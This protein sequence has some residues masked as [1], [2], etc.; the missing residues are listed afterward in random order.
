MD[1]NKEYL[2][3]Y[4]NK[5]SLK[6]YGRSIS[7]P[8]FEISNDLNNSMQDKNLY[9]KYSSNGNDNYCDNRYT[10]N[11]INIKKNSNN[12]LYDNDIRMNMSTFESNNYNLNMD[13]RE[14]YTNKKNNDI[15]TSEKMYITK[16]NLNSY[17]KINKNN[18]SSTSFNDDLIENNRKRKYTYNYNNYNNI[19]INNNN[20]NNNNNIPKSSMSY[21]NISSTSSSE[22]LLNNQFMNENYLKYKKS[23]PKCQFSTLSINTTLNDTI[24]KIE[25]KKSKSSYFP[26]TPTRT[27]NT[28]R[29]SLLKLPCPINKVEKYDNYPFYYTTLNNEMKSSYSYDKPNNI[30]I[31]KNVH[32][33]DFLNNTNIKRTISEKIDQIDKICSDFGNERDKQ[34]SYYSSYQT[35][36]NTFPKNI[37]N[38]QLINEI[39]NKK[40]SH[41]QLYD[42]GYN[43]LKS[44]NKGKNCN[45]EEKR[46]NNK[47][48]YPQSSQ[49]SFNEYS[50][51]NDYEN[52]FSSIKKIRINNNDNI[53]NMKISNS[54]FSPSY[55]SNNNN[56][57]YNRIESIN[58]NNKINIQ[59]LVCNN[60]DVEKG[61]N[62]Y[63]DYKSSSND[64]KN[65]LSY[66]TNLFKINNNNEIKSI[67]EKNNSLDKRNRKDYNN[68]SLSTDINSSF[69]TDYSDSNIKDYK[70]ENYNYKKQSSYCNE[71]T[72]YS[73]R[74]LDE[75]SCS[76]NIN[77]NYYNYRN[78]DYN[79]NSP[80]TPLYIQPS[81][82]PKTNKSK[83][84]FDI[85]KTYQYYLSKENTYKETSLNNNENNN[86]NNNNNNKL[87]SSYTYPYLDSY[88]NKNKISN[89]SNHLHTPHSIY[90]TKSLSPLSQPSSSSYTYP[91][92]LS[93]GIDY[94]LS[95]LLNNNYNNTINNSI[96]N[97]TTKISEKSSSKINNSNSNN[98]YNNNDKIKNSSGNNK[99]KS[100]IESN[101]NNNKNI[102]INKNN[103][104][105]F[106]IPSK[107]PY[108]YNKSSSSSTSTTSKILPSSTY[109]TYKNCNYHPYTKKYC[110]TSPSYSSSLS[111][112]MSL[113]SPSYI[114]SLKSPYL[115][116][117]SSTMST[118]PLLSLSPLE[119]M[120][121]Y[122]SNRKSRN[123]IID[124]THTDLYLKCMTEENGEN[125]EGWLWNSELLTKYKNEF[126]N[127]DSITIPSASV[128]VDDIIL[129]EEDLKLFHY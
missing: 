112:P 61:I 48:D 116:S 70:Y 16:S 65:H 14:Q 49:K 83:D 68:N 79:Y 92:K 66:D 76:W 6:N 97:Y 71:L 42:D 80:S 22:S 39:D 100:K 78:N 20:N 43:Y 21:N 57:N 121:S 38:V 35:N 5:N 60:N 67:S 19:Y 128:E 50:V 2:N 11:Y 13:S 74:K 127:L 91:K 129:T 33:D 104:Y 59:S 108:N 47:N 72:N 53:D 10:N 28:S 9:L 120:N 3:S 25:Q 31:N 94:I 110:M 69:E 32:E 4:S 77:D 95:S 36:F 106:I 45:N 64:K 29:E 107:F 98:L 58:R 102:N 99:Y 23:K 90:K 56:N 52:P 41:Q 93:S 27:P 126:T 75:P 117:L 46:S 105:D 89:I 24:D 54:F 51:D 7:S 18:I 103:S 84:T 111:S 109:S 88:S 85:N 124:L 30:I 62:S 15:W 55:Y 115:L 26:L 114:S 17:N 87:F 8:N 101:R 63:N 96:D 118:S 125:T 44:K 119:I 40:R 73:Q 12:N 37:S 86:N 34:N 123:E 113:L 122:P 81:N 1:T 82:D